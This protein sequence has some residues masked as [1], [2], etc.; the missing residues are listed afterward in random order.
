MLES[1]SANNIPG[2]KH[3][4]PNVV[5]HSNAI[6][7]LSAK[8]LDADETKKAQEA[9]RRGEI[10]ELLSKAPEKIRQEVL[11]GV[12]A[13]YAVN[14]LDYADEDGDTI[15]V[16]VNGVSVGEVSLLNQGTK[17]SIPLRPGENAEITCIATRDGGGGVTFR[18]LSSMGEMRTRTMAVGESET[19]TVAF[20]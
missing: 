20:K 16:L 2:N 11:S 14:L 3:G 1:G 8:D 19:W 6:L 17:L 12:Q 18:A 5:S 10:P 9:I 4:G 7:F 13:L 15:T